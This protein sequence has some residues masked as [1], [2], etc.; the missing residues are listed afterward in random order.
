[1][2][3]KRM[4]VPAVL[5]VLGAA[6]SPAMAQT[7][8]LNTGTPTVTSGAPILSSKDW[9][10]EEFTLTAGQSI[11]AFAA[12]LNLDTG[13]P[14]NVT[15]ALY[16]GST[17]GR[18]TSPVQSWTAGYGS[19]GWITAP[20][21][22]SYTSAS[23]GTYW[24]AI[25]DSAAGATYTAP[26]VSSTS[27]E[28]VGATGYAYTTSGNGATATSWTVSSAYPVGMQVELASAVPEPGTIG[29]ATAGLL[30]TLAIVR[31]RRRR[32]QGVA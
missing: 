24:L 28:P 4:A 21:S 14:G 32:A 2:N 15:F 22:D 26:T 13:N 10:A 6:A 23:G 31:L 8:V 18:N 29:L 11:D 16:A 27:L 25:E 12:Y 3:F 19:G 7:Y 17:F 5:A 9:F 1:M 20:A 30:A